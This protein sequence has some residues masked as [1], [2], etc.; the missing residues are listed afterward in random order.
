[1]DRLASEAAAA[2]DARFAAREQGLAGSRRVIRDSAN[3]I[4]ALH[5]GDRE[6]AAQLTATAR[7]TLRSVEAALGQHPEVRYAGFVDDAAKEYAEAELTARLIDDQPLPTPGELGVGW[8]PYLNGLGETVGE[9]RRHLLDRLR[10]GELEPAEA[11]LGRMDRI[12]DVLTSLDYPDG[13]TGG[14]RRTTDAAR[15]LIERSRSDLTLT[16]VQERL[17]RELAAGR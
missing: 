16:L 13:M 4:R 9:L 15:A 14:L 7:A 8:A 17:R 10:A 11:V 3:A 1:M 12:F 5:R 2:F 6:T